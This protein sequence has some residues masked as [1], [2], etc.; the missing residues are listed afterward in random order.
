MM[1]LKRWSM[2]AALYLA[3]TVSLSPLVGYWNAACRYMAPGAVES[4]LRPNPFR[5]AGCAGVGRGVRPDR[6]RGVPRKAIFITTGT[7]G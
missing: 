2:V 3:L 1:N 4:C 6:L 5:L 7:G